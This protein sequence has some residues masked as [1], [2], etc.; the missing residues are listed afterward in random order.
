MTKT[1]PEPLAPGGSIGIL[2]GGQLGRMTCLAAQQL[3]YN[4]HVFCP[5]DNAP[6]AQVTAFST[7]A[8]DND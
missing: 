6:A 5:E 2:G 7:R 4:C 3:G 8:P 1:T